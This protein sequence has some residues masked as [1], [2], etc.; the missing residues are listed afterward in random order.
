MKTEALSPK[1]RLGHPGKIRFR[2]LKKYFLDRS[3]HKILNLILKT[4]ALARS[5]NFVS[6]KVPDRSALNLCISGIN[7]NIRKIHVVNVQA[8]HMS[9]AMYPR[10]SGRGAYF[11]IELNDFLDTLILQTNIF[12]NNRKKIFSK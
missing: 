1:T 10:T 9:V 6:A 5:G 12:L 7:D 3:I 8:T 11:K 2:Y 4:E